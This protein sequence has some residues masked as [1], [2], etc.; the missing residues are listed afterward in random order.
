MPSMADVLAEDVVRKTLDVPM[1][2][3]VIRSHT[4]LKFLV[5]SWSMKM[6]RFV[7][8]RGESLL[9]WWMFQ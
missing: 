1:S 7:T 4:D 3:S 9:P 5:S 8:S 2:M 6:H